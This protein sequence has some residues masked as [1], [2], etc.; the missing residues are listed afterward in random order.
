MTAVITGGSNS[1]IYNLCT[2]HVNFLVWR[3]QGDVINVKNFHKILSFL[4]LDSGYVPGNYTFMTYIWNS[5]IRE[6]KK[7]F[8]LRISIIKLRNKLNRF[9]QFCLYFYNSVTSKEEM[10]EF[11]KNFG[12]LWNYNF[13]KKNK[14]RC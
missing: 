3:H 1:V 13:C 8:S 11:M 7:Y 10:T 4:F 2:R 9:K 12:K 6:W 5:C 14:S